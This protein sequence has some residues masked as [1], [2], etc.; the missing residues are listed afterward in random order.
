[1]SAQ[2]YRR[3]AGV[4]YPAVFASDASIEAEHQQRLSAA[5]K[6]SAATAAAAAPGPKAQFNC[7][8][9][10]H[11]NTLETLPGFLL[12]LF[13]AGLGNAELAAALGG[14]WVIG[15]IWFTLGE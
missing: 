5:S 3:R 11:A 2:Y 6:S 14:V 1:M 15:R 7:A 12:C 10:A 8:Q 9:R 4:P 13:V